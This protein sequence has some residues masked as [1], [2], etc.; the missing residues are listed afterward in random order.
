MIPIRVAE[1]HDEF[2]ICA[3]RLTLDDSDGGLLT[4]N[5]LQWLLHLSDRRSSPVSWVQTHLFEY[6]RHAVYHHSKMRW[7]C[8]GRFLS[9]VKPMRRQRLSTNL[10]QRL[11]CVIDC[12]HL[13]FAPL[14]LQ[15]S[16]RLQI[17]IYDVRTTGEAMF[18]SS[19]FGS[20]VYCELRCF[21]PEMEQLPR[22][23]GIE[24]SGAPGGPDLGC[25]EIH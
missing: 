22:H 13:V 24:C 12:F 1:F 17:A 8:Q 20:R 14:Q 2:L 25:S 21:R 15:E 9:E 10:M 19:L 16:A 11:S 6:C 18:T 23:S 7:R 3:Q 5:S 4:R